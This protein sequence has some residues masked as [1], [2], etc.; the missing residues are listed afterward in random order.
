MGI[1]HDDM[2]REA[3][4]QSLTAYGAQASTAG[5]K[6]RAIIK[7]AMEPLRRRLASI[8]ED[9]L[10]TKALQEKAWEIHM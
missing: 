9:D 6:A 5:K 2:E 10:T 3:L 4:G 1:P 7:K 8:E